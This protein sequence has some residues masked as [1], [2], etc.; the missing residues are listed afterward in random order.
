MKEGRFLEAFWEQS[1]GNSEKE[2]SSKSTALSKWE[3]QL[4]STLVDRKKMKEEFEKSK[5]GQR[6]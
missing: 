2:K 4:N 5:N 6:S 1:L 3:K